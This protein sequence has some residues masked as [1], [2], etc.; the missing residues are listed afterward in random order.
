MT[1]FCL[2][3]KQVANGFEENASNTSFICNIVDFYC[4][5][6]FDTCLKQ[7]TAKQVS[8]VNIHV[9]LIYFFGPPSI[10]QTNNVKEFNNADLASEMESTRKDGTWTPFWKRKK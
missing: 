3:S 6:A 10:L 5:F 9:R 8:N 7:E 1:Y 4:R 2:L